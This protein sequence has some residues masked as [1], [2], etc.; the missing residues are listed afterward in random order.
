MKRQSGF[1]RRLLLIALPLIL[2]AA[3]AAPA[4]AEIVIK[5][6]TL[7]PQGSEWH[8]I[9]QDMSAEWQKASHG[10][11]TLRIYPGGVAG[12][13]N[14][15]VRKMRLGT[16]DAGLLTITGMSAVDRSVLAMEVPLAYK[17]YAELDCVL[18]KLSPSLEKQLEAKGFLVLGWSEGGWT[19]FLTKAP[20]RT[21]DDMR[22]LKVFVWAGDDPYTELWKKAGFNP[23]PLPSTEISTALQTGLVTAVAATTQGALLLQW[24]KHLNY[25]TDL[26]WAMLL[27]GIV[28]TK[29]AWAKIPADMRQPL[30]DSALK[31]CKR[32]RD[33]SRQAEARD[34]EVLEKQGVKIIHTDDAVIEQWRQLI[35]GVIPQVRGSYL[36][37]ESLDQ[38]YKFRDECRKQ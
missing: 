11:V 26:K 2:W 35:K 15:I 17:D 16:I 31:A 32:L 18:A 3:L 6:A 29:S 24:Y 21:P 23:V 9:L 34:F 25:M 36:P 8:R 13:D 20:V 12:D 7:V 33:F 19:H 1:L 38:A 22:K 28:I 14:D 37:A 5:T 30:R 27:G 4:N 10:Q